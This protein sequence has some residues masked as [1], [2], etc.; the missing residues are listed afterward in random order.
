MTTNQKDRITE[1]RP[2]SMGEAYTYRLDGGDGGIAEGSLEMLLKNNLCL[3]EEILSKENLATAHKAVLDNKGS[4]GIDGMSVYQL[5]SHLYAI[6]PELRKQ[7]LEGNYRPAPVKRVE[8][9]KAEG[10][11][12]MLGIPT[13]R[14]RFIQQAVHQILQRYIDPTFSEHSYGF[15]PN[16]SAIDAIKKSKEYIKAG[17]E[18]VVDIDLEKFFDR[19]NHDKLMSELFKRIGDQRVLQLIRSYL[20]AGAIQDGLFT[21]SEEGTPQGGPLSPLLSNVMLDL[22]DKELEARGHKFVRYADDCNVYVR[23]QKAG[24]RVMESLKRYM[25]RKLKL[26]VNDDKSAVDK[27]DKRKFLGFIMVRRKDQWK[28]GMSPA[29]LARV[30]DRI[31]QITA[32]NRGISMNDMLRHLRNYLGGWQGYYGHIETP[33]VLKDLDSWIRHRLRCYQLHQWGKGTGTYKALKSL[34]ASH[35]DA[36]MTCWNSKGLWRVS[37]GR[38][39]QQYLPNELLRRMGYM[40]LYRS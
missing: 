5:K 23:T 33:T 17:Y 21:G 37:K 3:M 40:P 7:L 31:R 35:E 8:I 18:I 26:K 10:G 4:P 16:R 29:S 14:D 39:A 11:K 28:I 6:W 25:T 32:M 15:R 1:P 34:G 30:K 13:V 24:N 12:R 27:V 22:L 38:V 20:N 19:V 2:M 9:P 36:W